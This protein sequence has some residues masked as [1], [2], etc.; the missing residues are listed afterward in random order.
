MTST[1]Q[2]RVSSREKAHDDDG[3]TL[4]ELLVVVV[5]IGVLIAIAVPL[6][7]NYKKGAQNTAASSD[8]RGGVSAVEQFYTTNANTYPITQ[9]SP[10]AGKDVSLKLTAA[11][12]NTDA[13]TVS[14][15]NFVKFTP[16]VIAGA[17]GGTYYIICGQFGTTGTIYSYN[18]NVSKS[19]GK[20]S[21]QTTLAACAAQTTTA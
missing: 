10:S 9:V 2:S 5:I 20:S 19:V 18:S 3:F 17:T 15:G 14:S 6:Y 21:V 13:I 7:S 8:V 11:A 16:F 12:T 1:L 4:I